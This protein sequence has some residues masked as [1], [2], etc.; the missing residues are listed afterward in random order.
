MGSTALKADM[1][2][3]KTGPSLLRLSG[4]DIHDV[5]ESINT[6]WVAETF[7]VPILK[8]VYAAFVLF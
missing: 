1:D 7:G 2:R 5:K 8:A 4:S 3:C 6:C